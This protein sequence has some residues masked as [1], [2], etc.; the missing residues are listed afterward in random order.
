MSDSS[1]LA[2][3]KWRI[4]EQAW[5]Q[6][7]HL[8]T[9]RGQYLGFFFT[10][11]IGVTVVAAN[12]IADDA[13]RTPSS[14]VVFSAL[15]L[16]LDLLATL[17]LVAV[18]RIGAVLRHYGAILSAIQTEA[19]SSLDPSKVPDWLEFPTESSGGGLAR[20]LRSTQG[21]AETVLQSAVLTFSASLLAPAVRSLTLGGIP[22]ATVALCGGSLLFGV[23]LCA[24]C[25]WALRAPPTASQ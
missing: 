13:L 2:G 25:W 22:P 15:G 12:E 8:E 4:W 10:V 18:S 5:S 3:V 20:R 24:F 19:R 23:G 6:S 11:L 21:A 16:G 1:D 9:M 14:L 17:L 7:R